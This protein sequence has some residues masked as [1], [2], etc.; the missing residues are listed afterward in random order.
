MN[1]GESRYHDSQHESTCSVESPSKMGV[2]VGCQMKFPCSDYKIQV[3]KS[4]LS[5]TYNE[6][7]TVVV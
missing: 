2:A 3:I 7:L 5:A 4:H 6:S 1:F